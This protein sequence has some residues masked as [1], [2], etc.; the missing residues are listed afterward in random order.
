MTFITLFFLTVNPVFAVEPVVQK[1]EAG[2]NKAPTGASPAS[3]APVILAP[4]NPAPAN[5]APSEKHLARA[6][7]FLALSDLENELITSFSMIDNRIGQLKKKA[8]CEKNTECR[9]AL[10]NFEKQHVA[11]KE[12]SQ[13]MLR[14]KY[15][16][17]LA[18]V[19]TEKELE[20]LITV[21]NLPTYK[22][23]KNYLVNDTARPGDKFSRALNEKL[24]TELE[25]FL[26]PAGSAKRKK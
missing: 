24:E 25:K 10:D 21:Y 6:R 11:T 22:K 7:E 20:W 15:A 1:K 13:S 26:G 14:E 18:N 8:G 3:A 12:Q 19:F 2:V 16:N 9:K 5:P 4:T 23:Y 17:S